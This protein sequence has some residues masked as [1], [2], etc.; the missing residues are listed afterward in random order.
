MNVYEHQVIAV[1]P[2]SS[3]SS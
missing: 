2:N 3:R 1:R